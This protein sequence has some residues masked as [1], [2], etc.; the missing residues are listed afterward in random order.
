MACRLLYNRWDNAAVNYKKTTGKKR[1]QITYCVFYIVWMYMRC[2][3]LQH[4][5]VH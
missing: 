2:I 3:A 4:S 1:Y 5:H